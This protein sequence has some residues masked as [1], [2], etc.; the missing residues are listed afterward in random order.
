MNRGTLRVGAGG[1]SG[2]LGSGN[3][4]VNT[5]AAL[6]FSRADNVSVANVISG[7]GTLTK[8]GPGAL[9]LTGTNS[10]TGT[11]TVSSGTLAIGNDPGAAT[12]T[13]GWLA[14]TSVLI[15]NSGATLLLT[16]STSV[17][18]RLNDAAPVTI[19]GAGRFATA[20]L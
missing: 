19:R 4:S 1:S 15:I 17:I 20:G 18:D 6:V 5:G 10:Y 7:G 8:A 9:T 14:G 3:V 12:P 11:T 2:T 13:A 16:G